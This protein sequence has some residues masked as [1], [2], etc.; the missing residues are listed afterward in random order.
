MPHTGNH[1]GASWGLEIQDACLTPWFQSADK[2][3]DYLQR[4]SWTKVD[5][6]V[7]TLTY[8]M[9]FIVTGAFILLFFLLIF[10]QG[11]VRDHNRRVRRQQIA[12]GGDH[13]NSYLICQIYAQACFAACC[14]PIAEYKAAQLS[15]KVVE[16]FSKSYVEPCMEGT[17]SFGISCKE[18]HAY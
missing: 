10:C 8:V 13:T 1:E 15:L 14:L 11:A 3:A 6:T 4:R 17:A 9:G 18:E 2:Q 12:N 7:Y 5:S 16:G